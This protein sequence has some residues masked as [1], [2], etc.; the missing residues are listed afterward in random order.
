[1]R[2]HDSS[3]GEIISSGRLEND[4]NPGY[5]DS[6]RIYAIQDVIVKGRHEVG[7]VVQDH[8]LGGAKEVPLI[9]LVST[10]FPWIP[11]PKIHFQGNVSSFTISINGR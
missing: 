6:G 3:P 5:Q 1:M 2:L 4:M 11:V 9:A 10:Q 8:A 7:S